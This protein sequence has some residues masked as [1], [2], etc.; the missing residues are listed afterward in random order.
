MPL[1][2]T[3]DRDCRRCTTGDVLK[4]TKLEPNL[5]KIH[6]TCDDCGFEWTEREG[7]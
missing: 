7:R 6:F 1:A 4:H 3:T 5:R 2:R